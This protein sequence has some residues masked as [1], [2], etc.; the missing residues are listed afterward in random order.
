MK[1]LLARTK[2]A[3]RKSLRS[4][5]ET[6]TKVFSGRIPRSKVR[7]LKELYPSS[8]T[9]SEII[10]DLVREKL[11]RSEFDKWMTAI[12]E[13]FDLNDFDLESLR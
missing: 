2:P 3:G 6:K 12:Q 5:T 9:E 11:A 8:M 7:E 13:N 4:A 1:K 10:N